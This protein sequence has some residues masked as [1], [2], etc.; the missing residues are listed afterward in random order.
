[1]Q[2]QL[3]HNDTMT[4]GS[5][6]GDAAS[7]VCQATWWKHTYL[8]CTGSYAPL[9]EYGEMRFEVG[10][11]SSRGGEELLTWVTTTPKYEKFNSTPEL[12]PSLSSFQCFAPLP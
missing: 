1:M 7:L 10:M 12:F 4:Q 3:R 11:Y 6:A 9:T 8:Y 5:E 2:I